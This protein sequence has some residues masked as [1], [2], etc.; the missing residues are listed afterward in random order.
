MDI[1]KAGWV[2]KRSAASGF[3]T[4]SAKK[5]KGVKNAVPAEKGKRI[6]GG[7]EKNNTANPGALK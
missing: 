2:G 1:N 3:T 7:E 6:L 5:G 4:G